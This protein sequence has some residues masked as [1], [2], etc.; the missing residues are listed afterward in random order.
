MIEPTKT[1]T[2]NMVFRRN[3]EMH[4]STVVRASK[5]ASEYRHDEMLRETEESEAK[6]SKAKT[7]ERPVRCLV[8]SLLAGAQFFSRWWAMLHVKPV[9]MS[10]S[11]SLFHF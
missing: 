2:R 10:V 7:S 9:K 5:R 1:Q 4:D 11:I 6:Q 3:G 8:L